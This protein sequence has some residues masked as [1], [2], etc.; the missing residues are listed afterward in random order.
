MGEIG[1]IL[2]R[3]DPEATMTVIEDAGHWVIYERAGEFN[4]ALLDSGRY[5][6]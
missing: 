2:R 1:P 6:R 3:T 4:R 5:V